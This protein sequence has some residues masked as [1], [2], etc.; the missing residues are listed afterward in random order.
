M[1]K[2]FRDLIR[3]FKIKVSSG[4]FVPVTVSIGVTELQN[5]ETLA[6]F[7]NRSDKAMYFAKNHGKNKVIAA[8]EIPEENAG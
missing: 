5:G 1:R 4:E 6:Q 7:I 3:T 8:S 2:Y